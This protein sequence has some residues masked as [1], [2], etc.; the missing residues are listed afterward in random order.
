MDTRPLVE[1]ARRAGV[2]D[3]AVLAAVAAVDR[4]RFLPGRARR[5]AARDLPVAIGSG[6]TTSQPSLIALMLQALALQP[7][8][9]VLEVGTGSGYQ[10]ALLAELVAHVVSV[11]RHAELAA[12]ARERLADRPNVEVVV[13]DGTRGW[14]PQAPYDAIT[15]G[16]TGPHVPPAL[17]DQLADGGRVVMPVARDGL[18]EVVVVQRDGEEV[19]Q[20]ASLGAVRFVPLVGE[21]GYRGA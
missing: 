16:A 11:E 19:R 3:P 10:T 5:L 17:L 2:T 7:H 1:A 18:E 12:A 13:G 6:Q 8:H 15:V 14:P 9:R 20:V 21:Q 4:S